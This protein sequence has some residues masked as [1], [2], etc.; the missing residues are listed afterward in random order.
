MFLAWRRG[1]IDGYGGMSPAH[2]TE[3][4]PEKSLQLSLSMPRVFG[5]FFN[6][7]RAPQLED[8]NVR[9]AIAYA[10]DRQEIAQSQKQNK[11]IPVE[12]PLPW[13]DGASAQTAYPHDSERA[14]A[15]LRKA[16]WQDSDNDGILDKTEKKNT[17]AKGSPP[18]VPLHF[19]LTTSDW[20][21]LIQTAS[22]I[23][24]QLKDVGIDISIEKKTYQE[25]ESS[26]IRPRSFD[27]LLF[28]QVY[29]YEPDPFAFWHSS[30]VKDPGLNIT[31]FSDKK[32]DMLLED[33]RK[34]NDMSIRASSYRQ[35][36]D[37]IVKDLPALFLF[38]QNY[39]Y[40]L[41]T[42]I[43]GVSPTKISLPSDRFNEINTWYRS[44]TRV[45]SWH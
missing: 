17:K 32:A 39:L 11:A 3:V 1:T 16:G 36:S 34:T 38:T 18:V 24:R 13:I 20:P 33:I 29:G 4:N 15:L 41:P 25:L 21:D 9:E 31:Y 40:V 44:L 22:I 14:R 43:Q 5:I 2:S 27:M 10:I 45:F 37:I 19:T 30:Q 7:K 42:D 6:P 8:A 35:F 12:G 23:Q 26:V 28:G